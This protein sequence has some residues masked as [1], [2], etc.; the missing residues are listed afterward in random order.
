MKQTGVAI[1]KH[2]E[3]R[4]SEPAGLEYCDGV[5]RQKLMAQRLEWIAIDNADEDDDEDDE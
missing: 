5:A 2:Y 3:K 1:E 4:C